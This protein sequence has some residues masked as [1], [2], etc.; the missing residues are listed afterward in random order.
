MSAMDGDNVNLRTLVDGLGRNDCATNFW[1][2]LD[3]Q[4]GEEKQ[5]QREKVLAFILEYTAKFRE[6]RRVKM[7]S[8]PGSEWTFERML[9]ASTDCQL[10]GLERSKTIY[11]K[12]RTAIPGLAESDQNFR[13]WLI[14]KEMKF[15]HGEF[16]YSRVKQRA[17]CKSIVSRSNR[18]LLM[19]AETYAS[20]LFEDYGAS[21]DEREGFIKRFYF[22]NAIWLDYTA[23]LHG[24]MERTLKLLPFCLEPPEYSDAK[25]PVVITLMNA[26]DDH[27]SDMQRVEQIMRA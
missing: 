25:K 2:S 24:G 17:S 16:W 6:S 22:R 7:L 20:V 10:V 4:R 27:H 13:Y 11:L 21:V 18:L 9:C 23:Q 19:E 8:F 15:G 3:Y 14:E 12:A 1:S 5:E 26:R